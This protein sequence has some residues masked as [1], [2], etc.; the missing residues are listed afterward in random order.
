VTTYVLAG[1]IGHGTAERL[2][3]AATMAPS[4]HDVQAWRFRVRP[5]LIE[6][7]ADPARLRSRNDPQGR[8]L[9]LS[10][11]AALVNLRLAAAQLGREPVLRLLPD[12][13]LPTLLATVRLTGPHRTS[14]LERRLYA[15]TLRAAPVPEPYTGDLPPAAVRNELVEAARLEGADLH[16]TGDGGPAILSTRGDGPAEWLRAGQ[17]LQRVLLT[18]VAGTTRIPFRYEII[19]AADREGLLDHG[20]VPQALLTP[21]F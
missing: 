11:G 10:C 9:H 7:R 8:R 6:V 16:F 15:V 14:A 2:V 18:G 13:S 21:E 4:K 17:A 20:E 3:V 19:D 1:G 5:G 12:R